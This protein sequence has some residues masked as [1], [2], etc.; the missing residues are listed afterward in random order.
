MRDKTRVFAYLE[1]NLLEFPALDYSHT[2]LEISIWFL[3]SYRVV[4]F[5]SF[6]LVAHSETILL[7]LFLAPHIG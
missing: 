1:S 2:H 3:A 5:E 6:N 4:F 7:V